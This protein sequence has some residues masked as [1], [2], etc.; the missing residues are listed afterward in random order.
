MLQS[1]N[2]K[3]FLEEFMKNGGTLW[4]KMENKN[5]ILT[6]KNKVGIKDEDIQKLDED[7]QNAKTIEDLMKWDE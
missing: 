2:G 3:K 5:I 7:I 1:E 6:T 4:A